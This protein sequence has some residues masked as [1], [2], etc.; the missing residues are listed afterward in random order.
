MNLPLT[1]L[2]LIFAS[3]A[4]T[5]TAH[6]SKEHEPTKLHL[7]IK[8]PAVHNEV[9]ANLKIHKAGTPW[10][11]NKPNDKFQFI[12]V[13]PGRVQ[14]PFSP[15]RSGPKAA[16]KPSRQ[17]QFPSSPAKSNFLAVNT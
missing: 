7:K 9:M 8:A 14:P 1:T 16:S 5:V 12:W 3:T 10:I 11:M 6:P 15:I 2:L 13:D 17:K 4:L